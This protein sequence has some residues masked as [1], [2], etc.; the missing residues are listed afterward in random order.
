MSPRAVAQYLARRLPATPAKEPRRAEREA[1]LTLGCFGGGIPT[2][3]V[4]NFR[5]TDLRFA[6]WGNQPDA[7]LVGAYYGPRKVD[8]RVAVAAD[9]D[10]VPFASA[11]P[12]FS[13]R[14]A[15]WVRFA[16]H[17]GF[18]WLF[19][20]ISASGRAHP[21]HRLGRRTMQRLVRAVAQHPRANWHGLRVGY[22]RALGFVGRIPGQEAV[23]LPVR[24]ALQWRS[25]KEALGSLDV[26][27]FENA[28]MLFIASFHVHRI[29]W[30]VLWNGLLM[31]HG[32]DAAGRPSGPTASAAVDR[33]HCPCPDEYSG[34]DDD[35]DDLG[36]SPGSGTDS[37]DGAGSAT[38]SQVPSPAG[39][40]VTSV[41]VDCNGVACNRHIGVHDMDCW[42]CEV[43]DCSGAVCHT[44]RP[45][46][47]TSWR[48]RTHRR[49]AQPA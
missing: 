14:L 12:W 8:R 48:C 3:S 39:S 41:S 44:C 23:P 11:S 43:P 2:S 22:A 20:S 25:N 37:D 24:N 33:G 19:P 18:K 9:P 6:S 35:S 36:P 30:S 45:I 7:G 29:N 32:V 10:P 15:P 21:T 31:F 17:K 38:G 16:V 46:E 40:G 34:S 42:L 4:L 13:Q 1:A 5:P 49:T 27:D 47:P 26:Y 28:E